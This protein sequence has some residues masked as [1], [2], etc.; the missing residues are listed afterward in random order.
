MSDNNYE[1]NID[2]VKKAMEEA[3]ERALLKISEFVKA[4]ATLLAPTDRGNLKNSIDYDI[5]KSQKETKIGSSAE[6]AIYVEKGT[7]IHAEGGKGRKTPW[8][9]K[10]EKGQWHYTTGQRPQP[11]LTPSAERNIKIIESIAREELGKLD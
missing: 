2:K 7:G 3:E 8:R 5:N 4:Q 11:Y 10:D 9:Y 6:Y 1:S